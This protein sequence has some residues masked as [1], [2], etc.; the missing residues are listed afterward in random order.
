MDRFDLFV[1]FIIGGMIAVVL[2]E[3]WNRYRRQ[4]NENKIAKTK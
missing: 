3:M 1:M 2:H 4:N